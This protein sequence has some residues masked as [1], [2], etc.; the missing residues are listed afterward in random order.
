[1]PT[2]ETDRTNGHITK[3]YEEARQDLRRAER[4]LMEQRERVAEL[5]RQLPAGPQVQDHRFASADGPVLLSELFTTP[6]RTLMLYHFMYG[7][8]QTV[9][10]PMCSMWAD[11]WNAVSGHLAERIDLAMVTAAPMPETARLAEER[12][13][14]DLRWLSAADNGFKAE[15]GGED[16]EGNQWPFL[17][18]YRLDEAGPRLTWSGGANIE[19]DTWRGLDLLSPVWHLLDLTPEGRGDWMPSP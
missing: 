11:G 2:N 4:E 6:D 16:G 10:C 12:G 14:T 7:K 19:G 9:P 8:R 18:V 15:I 3:G 5:R 1:M 13:W 17:S